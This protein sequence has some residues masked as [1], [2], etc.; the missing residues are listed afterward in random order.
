MSIGHYN[1]QP[2]TP[3]IKTLLIKPVNIMTVIQMPNCL[4]KR[5]ERKKWISVKIVY[6]GFIKLWAM[7]NN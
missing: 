1:P 3:I 7:E 5:K 2:K 4:G 6:K